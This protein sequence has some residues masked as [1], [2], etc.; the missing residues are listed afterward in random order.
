MRRAF[1]WLAV[2][3][4]TPILLFIILTALLYCPPV[5][6]WAVRQVASY[7]SRQTGMDIS[8]DNVRLAFPLDL[9][10]NGFKMIKQ[11]DTIADVRRLIA[12]VSL[13]PLFHGQVEI[14]ALELNDAKVN[15]TDFI[16][17]ARV[18]GNI[19]RLYLQSRGIDL[20]AETVKV[21]I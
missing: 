16:P 17:S 19:G 3:F 9:E 10:V 4:F 8:I 13:R 5:Q 18:K 15:T 12:D 1:K 21:A 2:A 20:S 11:P 14:N 7:A 6:N